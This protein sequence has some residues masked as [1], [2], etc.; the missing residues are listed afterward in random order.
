MWK[1]HDGGRV[2][3]LPVES[4]IPEDGL[5]S[6]TLRHYLNSKPDERWDA[7]AVVGAARVAFVRRRLR[8]YRVNSDDIPCTYDELK[9][10]GLSWWEDPIRRVAIAAHD[11]GF[12]PRYSH[13]VTTSPLPDKDDTKWE[14][15]KNRRYVYLTPERFLLVASWHKNQSVLQV[16]TAFRKWGRYSGSD[17]SK[18]RRRRRRRRRSAP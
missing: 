15:G 9:E 11:H 17:A 4:T 18:K 2:A 1:N 5:V 13:L 7:V 14:R 3:G 10:C 6:H 8:E 12:W 16:V